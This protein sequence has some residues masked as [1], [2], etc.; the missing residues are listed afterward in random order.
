MH[1]HECM[2]A[3][4]E[5]LC[6]ALAGDAPPHP[7]AHTRALSSYRSG[8]LFDCGRLTVRTPCG[9]VG[10]GGHYHSQ[11]PESYF[12]A[13]GDACAASACVY[14]SHFAGQDHSQGPDL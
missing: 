3:C 6:E 7:H 11:S 5:A 1:A 12:A 14:A 9:A 8:G 13:V 4:R 10:H 2:P